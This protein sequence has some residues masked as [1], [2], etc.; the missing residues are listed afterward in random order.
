MHASLAHG[1]GP[2]Q[3]AATLLPAPCPRCAMSFA[4]LPHGLSMLHALRWQTQTGIIL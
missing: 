4:Q 1:V 3:N 2:W